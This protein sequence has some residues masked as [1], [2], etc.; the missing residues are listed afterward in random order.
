MRS[1]T[2]IAAL[3]AVLLASARGAEKGE[4]PPSDPAVVGT[5]CFRL[6]TCMV[7]AASKAGALKPGDELLVGRAALLVS[8]AK[9]G[10]RLDAW[11]EWQE[12][13]RIKVRFLR[14]AS[15]AVAFVTKETPMTGVDGKPAANIRPGDRVRRAAAA[16][17]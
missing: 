15:F 11:G 12:V 9:G 1:G 8:V 3:M 2:V 17:K 7:V 13:G 5:V 16:P 14:G 10:E 4:A 6:G